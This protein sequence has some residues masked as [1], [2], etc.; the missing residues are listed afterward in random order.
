MAALSKNQS[1]TNLLMTYHQLV[2]KPDP[3]AKSPLGDC[4]S[5]PWDDPCDPAIF[6]D[7][8]I[9]SARLDIPLVF[10]DET[11]WLSISLTYRLRTGQILQ[12]SS[13]IRG[14]T[15]TTTWTTLNKGY[16]V[17]HIAQGKATIITY[18]VYKT[19]INVTHTFGAGGSGRGEVSGRA[20]QIN[21][22]DGK[23]IE[24]TL[25]QTGIL[26]SRIDIDLSTVRGAGYIQMNDLSSPKLTYQFSPDN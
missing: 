16:P 10:D 24:Q 25:T 18:M 15:R 22:A 2:P 21:L 12:T 11:L 26:D 13:S 3:G 23:E 1:Q 9:T 14:N 20:I 4:G 7:R 17:A 6:D 8:D 5:S 19:P